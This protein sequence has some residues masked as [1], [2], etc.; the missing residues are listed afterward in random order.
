MPENANLKN[1]CKKVLFN[2]FVLI[3]FSWLDQLFFLVRIFHLFARERNAFTSYWDYNSWKKGWDNNCSVLFPPQKSTIATLIFLSTCP[4]TTP[5]SGGPFPTGLLVAET[6]CICI[7]FLNILLSRK[8]PLRVLPGSLPQRR[9]SS[10]ALVPEPHR[11]VVVQFRQGCLWQ[12]HFAQAFIFW[13]FFFPEK[14]HCE[15]CREAYHSDADLLEHISLNH[16]GQWCSISN[17]EHSFFREQ[18]HTLEE[19]QKYM[20]GNETIKKFLVTATISL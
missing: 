9:W 5:G 7:Y 4:W 19:A 17:H 2:S 20:E 11:A 1:E 6:L 8:V 13:T 10:W 12:K 16:T 14:Y 15:S 18:F 3:L